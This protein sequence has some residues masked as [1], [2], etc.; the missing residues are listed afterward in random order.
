MADNVPGLANVVAAVDG[1]W[2]IEQLHAERARKVSERRL[3]R[4]R[5]RRVLAHRHHRLSPE[6]KLNERLCEHRAADFPIHSQDVRRALTTRRASFGAINMVGGLHGIA[7]PTQDF[8]F[9]SADQGQGSVSRRKSSY[10]P[11]TLLRSTKRPM[12]S[13]WLFSRVQPG[14]NRMS[15]VCA[16]CACTGAT[17]V[18][19]R[20]R[21]GGE[22]GPHQV[23]YARG[24]P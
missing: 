3:I 20:S 7:E 5:R 21:W 15:S 11:G 10:T 18:R 2:L 6:K 23:T 12:P 19:A 14:G 22:V 24:A 9:V 1:D 4:R 16:Q 13:L 8:A 17:G